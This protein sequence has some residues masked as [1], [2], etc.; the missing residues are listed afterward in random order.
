[1][2]CVHVG[3]LGHGTWVLNGPRDIV[4]RVRVSAGL[5]PYR[6]R[7][8]LEVLVAHPGGPLWARKDAGH[9]SIVKG[10][11]IPGEDPRDAAAREFQ[12]ETSWM[13]PEGVW[14]DLGSVRLKSGKTVLG[15][16]VEADLDPADLNPGLFSM[17][18][19]GRRQEFPEIDRVLWCS[20]EEA[21]R[22]LNPAQAEFILRLIRALAG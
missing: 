18:W 14:L 13:V 5:M 6:R 21:Q 4:P 1:M 12:E 3:R 17:V 2:S 20:P 22:L 10:E 7:A 16:A 8:A 9:W 11:V 19:R 15:W